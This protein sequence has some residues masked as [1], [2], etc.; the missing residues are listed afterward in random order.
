[1]K[2]SCDFAA[3]GVGFLSP[4]IL[5]M[6]MMLP[7]SCRSQGICVVHFGFSI[8]SSCTLFLRLP[9]AAILRKCSIMWRSSVW[10]APAEQIAGR[11]RIA[12]GQRQFAESDRPAVAAERQCRASR[13]CCSG[14]IQAA[15]FEAT[16]DRWL[17][18]EK[19]HLTVKQ[20]TGNQK[21]KYNSCIHPRRTHRSMSLSSRTVLRRSS[22]SD[23]ASDLDRDTSTSP[24][25]RRRCS[26]R[27]FGPTL[28]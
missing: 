22:S 11:A 15:R 20:V 6:R 23:A 13:W 16:F 8:S 4:F 12:K 21:F 26:A 24:W 19:G 5:Y 10:N 25:R 27:F 17:F 18:P 9:R 14:A 1:M 28:A 7:R 2:I 3:G